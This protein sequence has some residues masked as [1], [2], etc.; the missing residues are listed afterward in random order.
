MWRD[1]LNEQAEAAVF[2]L[3]ESKDRFAGVE[4]IL[5][6]RS[7]PMFQFLRH[8]LES[9]QIPYVGLESPKASWRGLVRAGFDQVFSIPEFLELAQQDDRAASSVVIVSDAGTLTVSELKPLAECI[10]TQGGR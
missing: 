1:Q 8:E 4:G 3:L 5:D 2:H 6:D 9:R 7:L 10:T